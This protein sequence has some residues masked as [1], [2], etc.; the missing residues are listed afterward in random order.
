MLPPKHL[1]RSLM[2]SQ[3]SRANFQAGRTALFGVMALSLMLSG[4]TSPKQDTPSETSSPSAVVSETAP[5][6]TKVN[7][8]EFFNNEAQRL[9]DI[10]DLKNAVSLPTGIVTNSSESGKNT[11]VSFVPFAETAKGWEYEV[12]ES[13]GNSDT[14]VSF[15]RWEGKTYVVADVLVTA[16]SKGSGLEK[17]VVTNTNKTHVIDAETGKMIN[18]VES[19]FPDGG[20]DSVYNHDI[21][22]PAPDEPKTIYT[23]GLVFTKLNAATRI[24]NPLTGE[25]ASE[26]PIATVAAYDS[27]TYPMPVA[28]FGDTVV[29]ANQTNSDKKVMVFNPVTNKKVE[30][31]CRISI[32]SERDFSTAISDNFRYFT[33][34]GTLTFDTETN[35]VFCTDETDSRAAVNGMGISNEGTVYG[36][37]NKDDN[38]FA[39]VPFGKIEAA[40]V[41]PAGKD[42]PGI[43]TSDGAGVFNVVADEYVIV[44]KK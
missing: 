24:I 32:G 30:T 17:D 39:E 10:K 8:G 12:P 41:T 38:N 43:I 16:S 35:T 3:S 18:V 37:V 22:E 23:E 27:G 42:L 33:L 25:T 5:A 2:H 21:G 31:E 40:K 29:V 15:V 34:G 28:R 26:K 14:T 1:E 4:C 19:T 44:P 7:A 6:V 9:L 13:D 36:V 11:K 20:R